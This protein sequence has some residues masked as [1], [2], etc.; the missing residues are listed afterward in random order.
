MM[1]DTRNVPNS[2]PAPRTRKPRGKS[3]VSNNVALLPDIDGRTM[4]GRRYRDLVENL[5]SDQGGAS[6]LSEARLQLVRR[7]AACATL[8]E[9][10]EA[11]IVRGE[12]VSLAE[13]ASLCSNLVRLG[14]RIGLDRIAKDVTPSLIER[15]RAKYANKPDE[16]EEQA[17]PSE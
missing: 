11:A 14:Q 12:P 9:N 4:L 10:M 2:L 15:L 3:R 6:Q 13:H 8:A 1:P 16:A 17:L 7:F 5:I